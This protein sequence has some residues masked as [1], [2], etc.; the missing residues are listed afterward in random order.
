MATADNLLNMTQNFLTPDLLQKFSNVIG[1][2]VDKIQAGLKSVLPTLLLG[3]VNKGTTTEGAQSIVNLAKKDGLDP[4]ATPNFSDA[5]YMEKGND[6]VNGIFGANLNNITSTLSNSTGMNS[7]HITKMLGLIAPVVMGLLGSK[8]KREGLSA[9]GL[10]GFLGQQKSNLANFIPAGIAGLAGGAAASMS[11]A[12][13]AVKKTM[14]KPKSPTEITHE[15]TPHFAERKKPWSLLGL[16]TLVLL[17]ALWWFTRNVE[18]TVSVTESEIASPQPT[19]EEY[20]ATA[21]AISEL[22]AFLS[23]G[24]ETTLPARFAF[25]GLI[26]ETGKAN[27]DIDAQNEID[28]I[29]TAMQNFPQATARVEGFTDN[30]GNAQ[31]N[32]DLSTARAESV[33]N[34]LINRGID[35]SRIE[36]VGRGAEAPVAS[37]KDEAGRALNRR[38]EFIITNIR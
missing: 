25:Q 15:M 35:E 26:F 33:R 8:I 18:E 27:L 10:S 1:Q 19:P 24:D 31:T 14:S 11:S 7:S 20:T 38:I 2:P 13:G 32:I 16:I 6:A 23:A 12:A 28:E 4:S 36:A 3:L 9:S 29:A 17:G 5:T 22:G 21:P 37:N 30:T 34:E